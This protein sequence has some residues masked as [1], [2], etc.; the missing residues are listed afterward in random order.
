MSTIRVAID[1]LEEKERSMRQF[2][3]DYGLAL[4]HSFNS[5]L[6]DGAYAKVKSRWVESQV[7]LTSGV[8]NIANILKAIREAYEQLEAQLVD[9]LSSDGAA[10]RPTSA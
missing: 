6:V 7:E 2:S 1:V 5:S 10:D 8:D 4:Q 9:A 3:I